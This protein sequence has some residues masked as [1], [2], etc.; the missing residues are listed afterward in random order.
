MVGSIG[1]GRNRAVEDEGRDFTLWTDRKM[2]QAVPF[3]PV[4][5][6]DSPGFPLE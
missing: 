5:Q 6:L 3:V 1:P 2:W 4:A